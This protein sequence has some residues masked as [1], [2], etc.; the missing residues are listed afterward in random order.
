MKRV[1]TWVS[2]A[3]LLCAAVFLGASL[4][5]LDP[6]HTEAETHTSQVIEAVTREEQIVL[7]AL[8]IQGITEKDAKQKVLGVGI[9]GSGKKTMIQYNFDAKLGIDGQDV[10]IKKT[11]AHAFRIVIPDFLFIGHDNESFKTVVDT[12]GILSF[13]TPDIDQADL[14]SQ[15]LS[16]DAQDQYIDKNLDILKD[17]AESFYKN[18]V[19]SIDSKAVVSFEFAQPR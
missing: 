1:L 15:I 7:L 3:V 10:K 2:V 16:D 17:Q 6:F 14:I 18:L 9:P 11:S 8:G 13:A 19:Q 4:A 12:G 5:H